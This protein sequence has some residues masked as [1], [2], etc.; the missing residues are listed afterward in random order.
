M[1]KL[2][3][4]LIKKAWWD[5]YMYWDDYRSDYP[6]TGQK[7]RKNTFLQPFYKSIKRNQLIHS[8]STHSQLQWS[9]S[10]LKIVRWRSKANQV[11]LYNQVRGDYKELLEL[12][13]TFL[14]SE[15]T[16]F[17]LITR[18]IHGKIHLMPEK[19]FALINDHKLHSRHVSF[20]SQ[21]SH[22]G[23]FRMYECCLMYYSSYEFSTWFFRLCRNW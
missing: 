13:F 18:K 19:I 20:Y 6:I 8:Q 4:K 23:V 14:D 11:I 16:L 21:T 3:D 10:S 9:K 2:D 1:V 22:S 7:H 12:A 5:E 17:T 15:A